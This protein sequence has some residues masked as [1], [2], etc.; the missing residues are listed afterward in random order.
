MESI[1]SNLNNAIYFINDHLRERKTIKDRDKWCHILTNDMLI[2][3][4]ITSCH[5]KEIIIAIQNVLQ[6]LDSLFD[7]KKPPILI[8]NTNY[9]RCYLPNNQQS[10]YALG[11]RF[12]I[13]D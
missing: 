2:L 1:K 10:L 9:E 7:D 12:N 5:R 6:Q 4:Q 8:I 3:D 13:I 11:D